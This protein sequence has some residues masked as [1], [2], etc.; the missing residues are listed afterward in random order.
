MESSWVD[1]QIEVVSVNYILR[2]HIIHIVLNAAFYLIRK[3][4]EYEQG[5]YSL[6][7]TLGTRHI[8]A[9]QIFC[10]CT[11]VCE[12][13]AWIW[14]LNLACSCQSHHLSSFSPN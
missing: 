8:Y 5:S 9:S 3:V 13:L 6:V 14:H 4:H 10:I 12:H 11:M 2:K 1:I 7:D